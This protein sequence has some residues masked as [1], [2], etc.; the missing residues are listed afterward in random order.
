MSMPR[1]S[2]LGAA[3]VLL[4]GCVMQHPQN[5]DRLSQGGAGRSV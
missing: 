3:T 5:A 2:M 1:L 4:G